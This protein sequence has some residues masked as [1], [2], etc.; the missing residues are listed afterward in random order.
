MA[1]RWFEPVDLDELNAL[2]DRDMISRLGLVYTAI[3]DAHLE[4]EFTIDERTRQPFGLLHGGVSCA[5]SESMG[6]IAANLCVDRSRYGCVGVE[7]NASH[8]SGASAGRVQAR[9][10]P[11]RVGRRMHVWQTDLFDAEGRQLCVS[12]LTVAVVTARDGPRSD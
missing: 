2:N 5:V 3:G 1:R 11:L 9:C 8:L 6:S 10:H 7:L 12:R 4:A